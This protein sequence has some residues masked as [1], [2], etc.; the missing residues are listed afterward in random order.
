MKKFL[1]VLLILML[2]FCGFVIYD[3]KY[4][5]E[6]PKLT[7]E[8]N[9]VTIDKLHIYGTHLNFNGTLVNDSNL[10]LIL[11]DGEFREYEIN[12]NDNIFNLSNLVNEGI[13]L[14]EIPIGKYFMFL[15][16]KI[17]DD[18]EN[19]RYKYY[20]LDNNTEYKETIYYTFSNVGNKIIINSDNE[21]NTLMLDVFKNNDIDIYDIVIDP[22]HGGMDGGASNNKYN[23]RDI[24]LQMAI[25]LKSKLENFGM[26]VKLTHVEGQL[27]TDEKLN[28]YGVNGRAV[29][30]SEVKAKYLFSLHM[31]SNNYASVNGLEIYTAGN[32]NYDFSKLLAKNIV[33]GTGIS[34]S[35]NKINKIYDGV[36]TRL[37]TENN[38]NNSRDSYIKKN[39]N[40]YDITINSNYYYMIRETGGII[41]GAYVD[42]RNQ[43]IIANP[44]VKSN[45]GTE[46]YL[47]ELGYISNTDDLNNM[48]NNMDKYV[49]SIVDTIKLLYSSNEDSK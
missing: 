45:V 19:I 35:N 46:A 30:S 13:Y 36:Y 10:Q 1:F 31:N 42:D 38:I 9:S 27:A 25:D 43:E 26:K 8:E 18:D 16:S 3:T 32:I 47:L 22:G 33:D 41:T 23:E 37:F 5:E 39:L 29:I 28:D 2:V 15:R 44:Y 40:P 21:Y 4:K 24:A 20:R 49:D 48:I 6:I 17:V 12:I 14:E 34:Y 7:I 11:Y